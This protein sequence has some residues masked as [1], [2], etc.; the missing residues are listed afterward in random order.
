MK[1]FKYITLILC[2]YIYVYNP[3]FR[4]LGFGSVKLLLVFSFAYLIVSGFFPRLFKIFKIEIILTFALVT[5][6]VSIIL[7]GEN[8]F[9]I[10][11]VHI[12]WFLESFFIPAFIILLFKN[13][14]EMLSWETLMVHVGF[15]A[16]MITLFLIFNPEINS[17]VRDSVIIDTLDTVSETIWDFRGFS[18]AESSSFGY[19][20][21]QG[22]ILAIC[23]FQAKKNVA[24]YI[25]II[26]L[27]VSIIFNART[28]ITPVAIS[29]LLLIINGE[30]KM[31]TIL[32]TLF[33]GLIGFFLIQ[34]SFFAENNEA[35][36]KWGLSIFLD[37]QKFL[38]GSDTSS[39][40]TI[41]FEEMFFLPSGFWEL[42]FGNGKR[43]FGS[44]GQSSDIGYI[45]QIFRGGLVYLL[46][47]MLFLI[48]MLSRILKSSDNKLFSILFFLTIILVNIKG[49]AF[50]NSTSFSR[51]FGFFYVLSIF[52]VYGINQKVFV[53]KSKLN[54][55]VK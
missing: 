18:I 9:S 8:T 51:L 12:V 46:I 23:L 49:D 44:S 15:L 39:N 32:V 35:S 3:I 47:M 27:F 33:V 17:F 34:H 20:V 19:G 1:I 48:F 38:E 25:P 16:S 28:G 53:I 52:N 24:F 10:P 6:S 31:K 21:V 5:Y 11:Y 2:L 30:L 13:D 4:F 50:F 45:I 7:L 14:I 40:Y 22:L 54:Y 43:V 29:I 42:I 26:F 55:Q 37:T 36:L 41:L